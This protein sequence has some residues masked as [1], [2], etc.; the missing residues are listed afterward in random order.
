M[1]IFDNIIVRVLTALVG[2]AFIIYRIQFLPVSD[3][4]RDFL[5]KYQKKF[6]NKSVDD[7]LY[8]EKEKQITE[9]LKKKNLDNL[10]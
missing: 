5:N 4:F 7:L 9:E 2:A 8:E 10:D 1:E 3:I 6:S